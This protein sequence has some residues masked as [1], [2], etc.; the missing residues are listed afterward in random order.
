[1]FS[2][3]KITFVVPQ[4]LQQDLRRQIVADGYSMK[5]KSKWVSEAVQKL[6]TMKNYPELV[7]LGDEMQKFE[8]VESIV[9]ELKLKKLLDDAILV[10]RQQ[11]PLLEGIKSRIIRTSILQRLLR[12]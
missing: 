5:D 11:Y 7:N 8:K 1:M 4:Q 6:L 12:S 2:K 10:I 9:I 3:V